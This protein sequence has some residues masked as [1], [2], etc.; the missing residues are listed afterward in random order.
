MNLAEQLLHALKNHGVKEIFGIPGDFALP[1]FKVIEESRILPCHYLSHEPSLGFAADAAARYHCRPSVAAVTYGAGGFNM[2]NPVAAAYAEKSP[3]IVISGGPGESD[4]G[5]GLLVHHQAKDLQSQL[6]MYKEVTCDQA[7]LDDM[8]TAPAV[9]ARV[10]ANCIRHSRPV[11]IEVPRDKV[12][13]SCEAVPLPAPDLWPQRQDA[14]EACADAILTRLKQAKKPV[15]LGGVEIRRFG[16]EDQVAELATR[17]G[18]PIATTL[19]ARGVMSRHPEA[20]FL[21]TYLGSTGDTHI[22][23]A[24]EHA[25]ATFC[26]GVLLTENDFVFSLQKLDFQN[27]MLA[28]DGQ[29]SMGF[30]TYPNIGLRKLLDTLLAR[31]EGPAREV[32]HHPA[33]AYARDFEE[34]ESDISPTDI[35]KLINRHFQAHGP[36]P[37]A[38]DMGDCFFTTLE[39]Q[40]TILVAP[41]FYATMG[42]GVPAGFGL[43]AASGQRPIILVGDGAFQMTGW[44]LLNAPRYGWNPIVIVFNNASWEML[45]TF[46][47]ESAFNDLPTLNFAQIAESLGGIG[48]MATNRR[49]LAE[50]FAKALVDEGHFHI[51]DTRIRKKVLSN[52]LSR[53]VNGFKEMRAKSTQ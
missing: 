7:V 14:L 15:I 21:G 16:V 17:L 29:C 51:I 26:I 30:H 3:V 37:I 31:L 35:A 34:D 44:E 53:F 23:E 6:N 52:T 18:I 28:A 48:H 50:V 11:Y 36:M 33:P 43:Q 1:F 20:P 25:D 4:R 42:Y 8:A 10:L 12:F 46:Q 45:R 24:V 41:G 40:N 49:E 5:H 19:M 2:L 38:A 22:R 13:S 39:I 27:M 47:P 32:S 9:I